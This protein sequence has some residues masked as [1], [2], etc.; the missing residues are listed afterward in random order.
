MPIDISPS[1]ATRKERLAHERVRSRRRRSA[2]TPRRGRAT[3]PHRPAHVFLA[4]VSALGLLGVAAVPVLATT[5]SPAEAS[6]AV[7]APGTAQRASVDDLTTALTRD[8]YSADEPQALVDSAAVGDER[9]LDNGQLMGQPWALPVVGMISD[10]FGPRP[11]HPVAG[12]RDFHAGTDI[13]APCG[14]PI[15]AATAG[16][17]V[18]AEPD[19]T[20]GNWI[21]LEHGDGIQTG[22]AHI[23][24]GGTEVKVG[25]NVEAGQEIAR[26][27]RTGAATGCHLHFETRISTKAVDAVPFMAKRGVTLG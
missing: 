27:G 3:H 5:G 23:V 10:G 18:Q 2:A 1:F 11:N 8:D 25:Q 19:G 20:Y 6:G 17:V 7:A 26:V 14:T 15:H 22:Y 12:T 21:L 16:T 24:N 9:V 4:A 13:A